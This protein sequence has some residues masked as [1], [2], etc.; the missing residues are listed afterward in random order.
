MLAATT[1]SSLLN[2]EKA[3]Y[4]IVLSVHDEL[5]AECNESFGS[6]Q[7]FENL[8]CSLPDWAE[9]LPLTAEGFECKRYRK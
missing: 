9:G 1:P 7:E 5:I 3:G 8:M 2:V 4:D 6:I